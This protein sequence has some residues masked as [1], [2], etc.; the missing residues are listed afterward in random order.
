[1]QRLLFLAL[2]ASVPLAAAEPQTQ[3]TLLPARSAGRVLVTGAAG[4]TAPWW[5]ADFDDSAWLAVVTPVGFD[6]A[7]PPVGIATA[8]ADS[9]AGFSGVQGSNGWSYGFYARGADTVPGYDPGAD[10]V[11]VAPDFGFLDGAWR[12][13]AGGRLEA[14]PPWDLIGPRDLHSNTTGGERWVIRRFT[15]PGGGRV[16]LAGVV[17]NVSGLGGATARVF[18]DGTPLAAFPAGAQSAGYSLLATLLPGSRVDLALDPNGA[19]ASDLTRWTAVLHPAADS[20]DLVGDSL[21]QFSGLAGAGPWQYGIYNRTL[22]TD[23]RYD[24]ATDFNRGAPGWAFTGGEWALGPDDP[25]WTA[26]GPQHAHPNG[27]ND[28]EEHWA[29]RRWVSPLTGPVT[30]DW[31]F[32]K[33]LPYGEGATLLVLHNGVVV[34]QAVVAGDDRLGSLR[35]VT[36]RMR[37]GDALD[38]ACTPV[39]PDG[40]T[41]DGADR[42]VF[43][44]FL[45][46]HGVPAGA[47][48]TPLADSAADW[49]TNGVQGQ[50][51]WFQGYYN[52]AA[53]AT[54]GYQA[55]DF[56]AFPAAGGAWGSNHFWRGYDWDW[57]PDPA[58]SDNLG[59]VAANPNGTNNGAEHWVIRRWVSPVAGRLRAQWFTRKSNP[60]GS[61][62]TGKLFHNG[63]EV[64]SASI[65]GND[66]LGVERNVDLPVVAIGDVVDLALTPTGPGGQ[67]DDRGD[68]SLN[69]LAIAS[70]QTVADVLATDLATA[71]PAAPPGPR[72]LL[73][74]PFSMA[75]TSRLETLIL[76]LRWDDGVIV[77]LNGVEVARRNAG[78]GETAGAGVACR[79]SAQA[80]TA[81]GI[82][83]TAMRGLLAVGPN[84]L[85]IEAWNCASDDPDLLVAPELIATFNQ[86][87]SV[88]D[89][90]LA[91]TRDEPL[92]LSAERL[93]ANDQDPDGDPL[94]LIS[95]DALSRA[96]GTITL[97]AGTATVTYLPPRGGDGADSFAYRAVDGR[98]GSATGTVHVL[99]VAGAVPGPN[100]LLL[101]EV[102]GALRLRFSGEAGVRYEFQRSSDLKAW[103]PLGNWPA[104][105]HG[106]IEMQDTITQGPGPDAPPA[107]YRMVRLPQP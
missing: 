61:G 17:G 18:V 39:G 100:Q 85:A 78:G 68:R 67:A 19:D 47:A 10:F 30:V 105:A 72:V 66:T 29:I 15:T 83:L 20:A 59:P 34:D 90:H 37:M 26:L 8:V 107:F 62:V 87:P 24:P 51:G 69:G 92:L 86:E 94:S 27:L 31:H 22:D 5:R 16:R 6:L 43:R 102:A 73:R 44:A 36:V 81:E 77:W 89:D 91:A 99:L 45:Y 13:G 48:C 84:L 80:L 33:D 40:D 1:M 101:E 23:G 28:G 11:M 96:G 103:I 75:D 58:P 52:R 98:G 70:C 97:D 106:L 57:H 50:R 49:G 46:A 12:R 71:N 63:V 41:G 9:V 25:P 76:R 32:A 21:S 42:C 95:V 55:G 93:L 60:F 64:D 14:D 104:P 56:I 53:D 35:S 38:F 4:L 7:P 74:L 79:T 3:Q 82:D 2:L 88:A 54:P 65:A